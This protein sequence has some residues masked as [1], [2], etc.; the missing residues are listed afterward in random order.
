MSAEPDTYR[1]RDG[2][3]RWF[4]GFDGYMEDVRMDLEQLE[5]AGPETVVAQMRLRARGTESGIAVDQPVAQVLR[6]RDGRVRR[7]EVYPTME[8]ARA[9]AGLGAGAPITGS[10]RT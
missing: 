8:E 6:L 1:G 10:A 9:A 7:I 3:R 2:I 4:G 5:E